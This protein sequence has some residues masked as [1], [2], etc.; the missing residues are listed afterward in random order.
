M[1]YKID[2]SESIPKMIGRLIKEHRELAPKLDEIRN[3]TERDPLTGI[4][5][6]KGMRKTIL[7]H[8]IEEE[9][10]VMRV[11]MKDAKEESAESVR[12]MQEHRWVSEFLE[13]RMNKLPDVSRAQ[14]QNEIQ[15]FL[16]DL[17]VHFKEEED[18]VFPLT[19]EAFASEGK[20]DSA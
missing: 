16:A 1:S 18:I 15:K 7:R 19:L 6:L 14:A 13:R 10:R 5:L 2:F 12:I 4:S 17:R 20:T 11:I 3:A 8:A 9:S